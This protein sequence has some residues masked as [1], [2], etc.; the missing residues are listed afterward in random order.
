MCV[1][2]PY[3]SKTCPSEPGCARSIVFSTP[4]EIS[5]TRSEQG[6][7]RCTNPP[8]QPLLIAITT[9]LGKLPSKGRKM[10]VAL[11]GSICTIRTSAFAPWI[12]EAKSSLA[13]IWPVIIISGSCESAA[14]TM[15][16][17]IFDIPA[18]RIRT[19]GCSRSMTPEYGTITIDANE[20]IGSTD[21]PDHGLLEALYCRCRWV[22][23]RAFY[24]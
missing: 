2:F 11:G 12:S 20:R 1:P 19:W 8:V 6:R 17:S 9:R 18:N 13:G 10:S 22:A 16:E 15:L 23:A 21:D 3:H 7:S 5:G 24:Y 4:A 14:V